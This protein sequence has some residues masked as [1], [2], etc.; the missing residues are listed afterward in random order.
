MR[1]L[2]GLLV[3]GG[4][5]AF[6]ATDSNAQ[7]PGGGFG[8]GGGGLTGFTLLSNKGVQ[9]EIKITEEQT[10]KIK[11]ASEEIRK[12][13]P[14]GFGGFGKK[15]DTPPMSKEEREKVAKERTEATN[16]AIAEILTAEQAKRFKQIERQQNVTTV[17]TNDEEVIKALA[18]TDDQ[19]AKIKGLI[20]DNAKEMPKFSKDSNFKELQEKITALRKE[21]KEKTLKVLTEEQTKKWTELTGA[22]FEVK[23]EGFGGNRK[24]KDD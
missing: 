23:L 9:E 22:A 16:K 17:L 21:L 13:Y 7:R 10:G 6:V 15:T 8:F 19:K 2:F 4:L 11:T 20:E 1:K 18:I 5:I 12:K 24:K 14:G 3:V